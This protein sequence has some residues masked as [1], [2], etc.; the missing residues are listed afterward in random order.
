MSTPAKALEYYLELCEHLF[1]LPQLAPYPIVTEWLGRPNAYF[2]KNYPELKEVTPEI[3]ARA[4]KLAASSSKS[5]PGR[6]LT[7]SRMAKPPTWALATVLTSLGC[8]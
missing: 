5:S 7:A 6:I 3:K 4:S 1:T 8:L 2:W